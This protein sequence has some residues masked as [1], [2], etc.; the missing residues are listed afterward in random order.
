MEW[1]DINDMGVFRRAQPEFFPD[2]VMDDDAQPQKERKEQREIVKLSNP[3]FIRGSE[4][5]R[6]NKKCR[7]QVT[8]EYLK[9]TFRKTVTFSLFSEYKGKI[10]DMHHEVIGEEND[11]IAVAEIT[12]YFND[13]Y[14]PDYYENPLA[15][16]SYF[17]KVT[18]PQAKDLESPSLIMPQEIHEEGSLPDFDPGM[19]LV[20]ETDI[21]DDYPFPEGDQNE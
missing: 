13:D 12:L 14:Y 5:F 2:C 15:E 10:Q 4:G 17:F 9:E 18:H 16:V 20:E 19:D 7:V 1:H 8:V 3:E 11:G 21:F 6:F